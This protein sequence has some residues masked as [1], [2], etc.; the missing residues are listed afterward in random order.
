MRGVTPEYIE[1]NLWGYLEPFWHTEKKI[2][3]DKTTPEVSMGSGKHND[4]VFEGNGVRID[5][6]QCI[7]IWDGKRRAY[8]KDVSSNGTLVNG[9]RVGYNQTTRLRDRHEVAFGPYKYIYRQVAGYPNP[10][11]PLPSSESQTSSSHSSTSHG[12]QL[13]LPSTLSSLYTIDQTLGTGSYGVVVR[14][15]HRPSGAYHALKMMDSSKTQMRM[16]DCDRRNVAKRVKEEVQNLIEVEHRHVC[17]IYGSVDD[18]GSGILTLIL[19]YMDGGDLA[20]YMDEKY[21]NGMPEPHAKGLAYQIF[22]GMAYVHSKGIMHR[23]LKPANIFLNKHH[24]PLVKIGDFG[25]SK[26]S[27]QSDRHN[28]ICGSATYVAPEVV[29]DGAYDARVDCYSAGVIIHVMLTG[30]KPYQSLDDKG[31]PA[32][33]RDILVKFVKAR[34]VDLSQLQ[35]GHISD[36]ARSVVSYLLAESPQ[37]RLSMQGALQNPWFDDHVPHYGWSIYA[38]NN[39]QRE[40]LLVSRLRGKQDDRE[41]SIQKVKSVVQVPTPYMIKVPP[42]HGVKESDHANAHGDHVSPNLHARSREMA[43]SDAKNIISR[44]G[45]GGRGNGNRQDLYGATQK[46][47]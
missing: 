11:A 5:E 9:S 23:D 24:P 33:D 44:G 32:K 7:L 6:T 29:T 1:A 21:P 45:T 41:K 36:D 25:L 15:K 13:A 12:T 10:A 31:R 30:S 46:C 37:L 2:G 43:I 8:L 4:V 42:Y 35:W 40:P 19:E 47:G 22:D 17:R 26:R 27:Y 34:H 39:A 28:S 20:G 16:S 3:L 14:A 38:P 18:A